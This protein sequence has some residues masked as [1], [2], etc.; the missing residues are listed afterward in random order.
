[1][2]EH[3]A[4]VSWVREGQVFTDRKYTRRHDISFDGGVRIAGSPTPASVRPPFSDPAAVDPEELLT[5]ALS[6]CHMLWFLAL[7]AKAGFVVDRY[8]D[9][10]VSTMARNDAGKV[11]I[12]GATLRPRVTF[13][14][15]RVPTAAELE[16]LHHAA[17]DECNIA[18]SVAFPVTVD[19]TLL[20]ATD[21]PA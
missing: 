20:V 21:S 17:H 4:G 6:S 7:A 15:E 18:N 3:V 8:E 2:S 19:G 14:G 1:M 13:S 11:A 12:T 10:A 16:A 5:A 9:E